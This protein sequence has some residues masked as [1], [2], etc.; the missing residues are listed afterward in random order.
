MPE[1]SI[2][3]GADIQISVDETGNRVVFDRWG[4]IG[5][6]SAQLLV[7]LAASYRD[8]VRNERAPKNFPFIRGKDLSRQVGVDEEALRRRVSRCRSQIAK[9]ASKAG[10]PAPSD[11]AVIENNPWH[12][13]R[14]NPDRVRIVVISDL[15]PA[16]RSRFSGKLVTSRRRAIS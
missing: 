15:S 7:I 5:G 11:E 16:E 14:L 8:A 6:A 12:G 10:D 9:L 13:Y 1:R 4:E 3:E 2:T